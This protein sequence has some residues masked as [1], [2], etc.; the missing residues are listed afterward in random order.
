MINYQKV[1]SNIVEQQFSNNKNV[2]PPICILFSARCQIQIV[3]YTQDYKKQ[4]VARMAPDT[5]VIIR[6]GA[7]GSRVENIIEKGT[8]IKGS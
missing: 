8:V 2:Q 6:L 4:K 3:Y 1:S 7:N 5:H